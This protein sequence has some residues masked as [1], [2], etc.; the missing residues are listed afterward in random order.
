[1]FKEI[2]RKSRELTGERVNELLR[3]TEYGFLSLGSSVNGYAY[4]IPI[5]Y[6]YD[7]ETN[8][9]YFHG[10]TEGQK[11]DEIRQNGKVSFCIVGRTQPLPDKFS[12][13]YESVIAFGEASIIDNDE[14]KRKALRLLVRKY[15]IDFEQ[16]GEE[17]MDKS[18]DKIDTFKIHIQHMTAKARY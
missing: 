9:L 15:S 16:I 5:N 12:T 11:L 7:D 2:R 13:I 10:A 3:T 6:A 4:G 14:E 18:W 1:M 8:S 17:Y